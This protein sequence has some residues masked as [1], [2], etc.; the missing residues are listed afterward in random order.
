M[1]EKSSL[2]EI[3]SKLICKKENVWCEENSKEIENFSEGYKSA[4][5]RGKT[6]RE[7]AQL[8]AEY[9]KDKGFKEFND[10]SIKKVSSNNDKLFR[11]VKD[12]VLI[13][14]R[15]GKASIENG[16]NIVVAH[17]DSPRLDLKQNPLYED[18]GFAFFDTHYY[19]GIKNYQWL[20][21]PLAIHGEIIKK[22]G[23]KLSLSIGEKERDPVFV[24]TDILPHLARDFKEKKVGEVFKAEELDVLIGGLPIDFKCDEKEA[25]KLNMLKILNNEYGIVEED[26]SSAEIEIVPRGTALDLGFDRSMIISYGQDDRICAY[27]AIQAI[28]NLS[29]TPILPAVVILLDKEEIGSEGNTGA[30]ARI[31]EAFLEDIIALFDLEATPTKILWK[32]N[33][34]SGDVSAAF[35]PHYKD[36]FEPRN[37]AYLNKGVVISKFTGIGGKSGS[38]DASAEFVGKIRKVFNDNCIKWQTAEL[39]KVDVG[40]GGTVAKFFAERGMEVLDCGPALLSMHAP[41]EISSKADVYE[42]YRA[43]SAFLKNFS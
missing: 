42:T 28:A 16:L 23:S 7:F 27:T 4:L 15:S 31:I 11:I 25:V 35:D 32:S 13:A 37:S 36:V 26:L 38:S 29:E 3:R 14:F 12:K 43:Y 39:G 40:G 33:C 18:S 30:K 9:L 21:I 1:E 5:S 19:G 6:E 2:E 17:I 8:S 34:L 41:F 20:S 10:S 22:D 24:I